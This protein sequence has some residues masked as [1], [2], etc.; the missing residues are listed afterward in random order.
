MINILIIFALIIFLYIRF[1]T[2]RNVID[3]NFDVWIGKLKQY[4][5]KIGCSEQQVSNLITSIWVKEYESGRSPEAAFWH[6]AYK[7]T[8]RAYRR[9]TLK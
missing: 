4:M 3:P 8:L 5:C 1:G 2:R 6:R 9:A 7:Q